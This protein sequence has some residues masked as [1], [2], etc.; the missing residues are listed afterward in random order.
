MALE[1]QFQTLEVVEGDLK[2]KPAISMSD[3]IGIVTTINDEMGEGRAWPTGYAVEHNDSNGSKALQ[4][5]ELQEERVGH[6]AVYILRP[7]LD[8]AEGRTRGSS[9]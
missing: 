2:G 6:I 1:D 9:N 4:L 5:Q 8:V 7:S 3:L